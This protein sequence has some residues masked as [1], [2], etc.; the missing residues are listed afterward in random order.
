MDSVQLSLILSFVL[1]S[2][3]LYWVYVRSDNW[4]CITYYDLVLLGYAAYFGASVWLARGLGSPDLHA[5]DGHSLLFAYIGIFAF[6]SV[7]ACVSQWEANG[8]DAWG[9][10]Y[11]RVRTEHLLFLQ[12]IA[13]KAKTALVGGAVVANWALRIYLGESYGLWM[14]GTGGVITELPYGLVVVR[15]VLDT[16]MWGCVLWAAIILFGDTAWRV[17][18]LS[19]VILLS[20][21]LWFL[22]RGR[23]WILTWVFLLAV[24]YLI[25]G[26]AITKRLV[27][28]TLAS[29]IVVILVV[30]PLFFGMR[31]IY[32]LDDDVNE[33][34]NTASLIARGWA[35]QGDPE[36]QYRYI[37]NA[38]SRPMGELMFLCDVLSY[39]TTSEPMRGQLLLRAMYYS[40]PAAFA[41][42][43]QDFLSPSQ[44]ILQ[45]FG[46]QLQD[47]AISIPACFLADWGRWGFLFGGA[48]VGLWIAAM[49]RFG[50]WIASRH[51]FI[52]LVFAGNLMELA[53]FVQHDPSVYITIPRNLSLLLV[54]LYKI[55]T[56]AGRQ[57]TW[58]N[59]VDCPSED[60]RSLG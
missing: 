42:R 35:I 44:D 43:K 39:T 55:D 48:F 47:P 8:R 32:Q 25:S 51:P 5:Y 17:R 13:P 24:G 29:L 45:Y 20:E 3:C 50:T 23:R 1:C 16:A 15:Q 28:V 18:T 11:G 52:L 40:V 60:C 34:G 46:Q 12:Q 2:A 9:G 21:A 38:S 19:V 7:V 31:Y 10:T 49:L 26:R 22:L 33:R 53:L 14:S 41:P 57:A 27:V 37:E 36:F 59:R 6:L 58:M 54:V 30:F 56:F 4:R